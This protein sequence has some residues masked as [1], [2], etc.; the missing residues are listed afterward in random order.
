MGGRGSSA[1]GGGGGGGFGGNLHPTD[2]YD[3]VS[4]RGNKT[5]EVDGV[6]TVMRDINNQYDFVIGDLQLVKLPQREQGTMAYYSTLDSIS[7]NENYFDGASMNAAY[8]KSVQQGYHPSRGNRSGIEAVTA[9]EGAHALTAQAAI[10]QGMRAQDLRGMANRIVHEAHANY[11]GQGVKF[12]GSIGAFRRA[13]SGYG[14]TN[15]AEAIA[16]AF[17]DVY[18]NGNSANAV[19]RA[20]VN[21]LNSYL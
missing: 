11:G 8:D 15:N 10:N 17:A 7:F 13:I 18:C 19:S 14:A 5:E 21:T 3:L 2:S 16:E 12:N 20:I 4:E 9:H 6:L 1:G